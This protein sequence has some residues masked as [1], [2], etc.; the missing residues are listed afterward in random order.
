MRQVATDGHLPTNPYAN[1]HSSPNPNQVRKLAGI[2]L[3]KCRLLARGDRSTL[4]LMDEVTLTLALAL[5]LT[6]CAS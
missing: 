6:R 5:T 4:F 2:I 1:P 3:G